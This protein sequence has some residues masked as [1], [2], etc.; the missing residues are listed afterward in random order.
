MLWV[1]FKYFAS[2]LLDPSV[3][4]L[5]RSNTIAATKVLNIF[6]R[7]FNAELATI[8]SYP[9]I[10]APNAGPVYRLDR[11]CSKWRKRTISCKLF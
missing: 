6:S 1:H 2:E 10:N 5:N 8:L 4:Q 11:I 3:S 9:L 7:G